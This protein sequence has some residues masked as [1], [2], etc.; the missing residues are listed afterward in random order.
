MTI[1]TDISFDHVEILGNT[2]EKIAGEKAGIIKPGVPHVIGLLPKEAEKVMRDTARAQRAPLHRL[3][4]SKF[5][6]YPEKFALDFASPSISV[7]KLSPALIG[8]HQLLNAALAL[9]ALS[10]VK[11]LGYRISDKAVKTGLQTTEWPGR[12]QTVKMKK[13]PTIILDVGHNVGGARAFAD[14]FALKYPGRKAHLIIGVVKRKQHQEMFDALA[15]I[16]ASYTLVRMKTKRTIDP[17]QTIT[18]INWR[19]VPVQKA[20][21]LDAAYR[22]LL[23]SLGPDD[24]LPVIGSHYLVGEFLESYVWK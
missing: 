23:K 1:C 9:K 5:T 7:R 10:L 12:F 18:E 15:P 24:I 22:K 17:V 11:T 3:A 4:D 13:R 19:G 8:R 6:T 14:S 2:L 16:A 21:S 20:G